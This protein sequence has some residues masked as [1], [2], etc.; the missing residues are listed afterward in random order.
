MQTLSTQ[1][2]RTLAEVFLQGLFTQSTG[3]LPDP[4]ATFTTPSSRV[5]NLF[6]CFGRYGIIFF[7]RCVFLVRTEEESRSCMMES[8]HATYTPPVDQLLTYGEGENSRS[9]DWPNYLELGFTLDHV[10][11]L[12]RMASDDELNNAPS[13][14]LE[15][16]AP[17]HAWRT[18]GQ[19]RAEAAIEPLAVLRETLEE[20]D[21]ARE[22]LP[23]VL[24]MIGPAAL[25]PLAALLADITYD[26]ELRIGV[27]TSIEEIGTHWPEARTVCVETLTKQLELFDENDPEINGFLALSLAKLHATESVPVVRQAYAAGCVDPMILGSWD[28]AQVE[29]GLLSAE[30]ATHRRA[31]TFSNAPAPSPLRETASPQI[32][33]RDSHQRVAVQK[34]AKSKMAKQSR[35]KNRKR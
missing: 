13:E 22:E 9:E 19:L 28:D 17:L 7:Q 4:L 6:L 8:T 5:K 27:I 14:S 15:V 1:K 26:D 16:W 3:R 12:I 29:F 34:K 32:A 31:R 23:Q 2:T 11:D 33:V 18:L 21:W 30:E 20:N 35:K 24:G 25:P 10:P